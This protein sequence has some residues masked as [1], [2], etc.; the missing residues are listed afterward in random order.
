MNVVLNEM[1][2]TD[3]LE[4]QNSF[5][6]EGADGDFLL[7]FERKL[8]TIFAIRDDDQL[9]GIA[10]LEEGKRAYLYVFINPI[11]RSKGIGSKA[12]VLCE[13]RLLGTGTEE[14]MSTYNC[15][16]VMAK[17]FAN[18]KGFM[19]K[20][21]ST[22]MRYL[23]EGFDLSEISVRKYCDEDYEAAHE[24]YAIA[25]HEM[26]MRVGDFPDSVV[27]KPSEE[28]RVLW[29]KSANERLVYTIDGEIVGYAH[30]EGNEIGSIAIKSGYQGQGLGRNFV[31][32]ICNAILSEGYSSVD[33]YCVVGNK[34][35][36]LYDL[37]G[38]QAIYTAEY[39]IKRYS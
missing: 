7:A 5:D 15:V 19:R 14:V 28:M 18:K 25:F 30:F 6:F 26:R 22:F 3:Y 10:Q 12:I 13:N 29:A 35:R 34:A 2:E 36:L 4:A 27:Q 39:A 11:Y 8:S 32:Y 20:F 17:T 31:K 1:N 38:F 24:L 16:D 9:V 21:S 37:L 23:G 33:L